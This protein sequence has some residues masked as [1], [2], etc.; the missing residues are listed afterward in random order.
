MTATHARTNLPIYLDY[1]ATTPHAPEVIAAMKPFFEEHFGNPSSS[2]IY[3]TRTREA[4][5]KARRQVAEFLGCR[6]EE[7]FFTS[8][9]TESNNL[10]LRGAAAARKSRGRHILTTRIEHP[11]ITAVCE[12]LGQ[13]GFEIE[14][15]PVDTCGKVSISDVERSIRGDTVLISVMHA[16]NE[17]GTIQPV[18]AIGALAKSSGLLFHTDAAQSAGKIPVD[19]TALGV[20]LLSLAGH[21]LY[22]PKGVGALYVRNG[23]ELERLLEGAGQ[24]KGLRP[25]TE[26]VLEIVGLG[27]ACAIAGANLDAFS[28]AMRQTRD[29]LEQALL[30]MIDNA[31]INGHPEDR[32]PNTLSISFAGV[33]AV[34]I[35]G[36]VGDVVAASAGAACHSGEIR[37]SHVLRAMGVSDEWGMGT[38]RFS[39][40]RQT[41]TGDVDIAA[42]VVA[43]A[44]RNLRGV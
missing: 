9:G 38:L 11:A 4:V 43:D 32:L 36:A 30:R 35:L 41:S 25:G 24:E 22:A 21:K 23:V 17:V 39:T 14:Y 12:R 18:E 31:R 40:G 20:D 29:H 3:G 44:V 37:L 42:A 1:N 19:V 33:E 7:I 5:E 26:N 8:G 16:N 28:A 2:H 27:E 34:R 13:E 10:A 15:L 6:P